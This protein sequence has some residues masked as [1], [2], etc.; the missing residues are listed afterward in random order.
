MNRRLRSLIGL[1]AAAGILVAWVVLLR[2]ASLGGQATWIVVRGSSMLPTY[3]TGDLVIVRAGSDYRV[4]DV[5]AYRVPAG[6]IGAGHVVIHRLTAGDPTAGFVVQGDNNGAPD[7]WR[8]R[9]SDVVGRAWITVPGG[10]RLF[11]WIHQPAVIGGL[12][13]ALVVMV[14]VGRPPATGRAVRSRATVTT[15]GNHVTD[16]GE[17]Q[18]LRVRPRSAAAA[19]VPASRATAPAPGHRSSGPTH[20]P[21]PHRTAGRFA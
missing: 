18:L 21:W 1:L 15:P 17:P 12:A 4:G 2:P 14:I 11:S 6:E 10:G 16:Q 13:A 19:L 5:V 20:T 7:P 9:A 8:P 3:R